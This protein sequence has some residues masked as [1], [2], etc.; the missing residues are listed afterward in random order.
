M[1]G[2]FDKG[3]I[4]V[5]NAGI[6]M[7]KLLQVSLGWVYTDMR[8]VVSFDNDARKA[9]LV[10]AVESTD[11]KV[12][13]FVPFIHALDGVADHLRKNGTPCEIVSG[14]TPQS[15]RNRIFGAFQ[16]ST[17]PRVIVAHPQCM[18]HGLTLTAADTIIWFGPF[19]SLEVFEQ[20][21]QRIRRVGQKHKQ[22]ILLFSG[23]RAESKLYDRLQQKKG[24]QDTLLDMFREDTGK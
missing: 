11:N 24:V 4:T 1:H 14:Q 7:N 12:I 10:D 3:E 22:Q 8:G 9:A 19:A 13:V 20:A 2:L 5:Q 6:L 21:N 18:A 16:N 23:T 15:E 17:E